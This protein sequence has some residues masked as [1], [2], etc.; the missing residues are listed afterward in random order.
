MWLA[1]TPRRVDWQASLSRRLVSHNA[2]GVRRDEGLGLIHRRFLLSPLFRFQVPLGAGPSVRRVAERASLMPGV[3]QD[4]VRGP[5]TEPAAWVQIAFQDTFPVPARSIP[6]PKGL[7]TIRRTRVISES[8]E[9]GRG[10]AGFL[11]QPGT[12]DAITRG[13]TPPDPAEPATSRR[14]A[15]ISGIRLR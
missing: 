9:S 1:V 10:N 8:F 5:T 12:A 14:I 11:R 7:R 6:V 13:T 4:S 3:A 15:G 2:R